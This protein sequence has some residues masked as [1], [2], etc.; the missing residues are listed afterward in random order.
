MPPVRN[1]EKDGVGVRMGGLRGG[2]GGAR[3]EGRGDEEG[4]R[5]EMRRWGLREVVEGK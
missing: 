3:R 4:G 1:W 5:V 2:Q